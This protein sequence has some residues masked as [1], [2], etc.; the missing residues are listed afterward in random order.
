MTRGKKM[1]KS[2][3]NMGS[4]FMHSEIIFNNLRQN[5]FVKFTDSVKNGHELTSCLSHFMDLRKTLSRMPVVDAFDVRICEAFFIYRKC[6]S[7]I[8]RLFERQLIHT[9]KNYLKCPM[10][11]KKRDALCA[12]FLNRKKNRNTLTRIL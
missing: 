9:R 10:G 7:Q 1:K 2:R 5:G 3:L 11:R 4:C 8:H 6:F 12:K